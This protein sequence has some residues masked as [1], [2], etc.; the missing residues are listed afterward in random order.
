MKM[1][2]KI[3]KKTNKI[4]I[5]AFKTYNVF[6][7]ETIDYYIEFLCRCNIEYAYLLHFEQQKKLRIYYQ[8]CDLV[9]IFEKNFKCVC[10]NEQRCI[11]H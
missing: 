4:K 3:K 11:L 5:V 1:K 10:F 8:T 6:F 7:D 2:K 9:R